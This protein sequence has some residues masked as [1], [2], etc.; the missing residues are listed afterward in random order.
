MLLDESVGEIPSPLSPLGTFFNFN[1]REAAKDS[2]KDPNQMTSYNS[3]GNRTMTAS[4]KI[5]PNS[6]EALAV[7]IESF[8]DAEL[9]EEEKKTDYTNL[10]NLLRMRQ[11]KQEKFRKRIGPATNHT[12]RD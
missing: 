12:I 1:T 9:M 7:T 4:T 5:R 2:A 10:H 6:P 8:F 11:E 3:F